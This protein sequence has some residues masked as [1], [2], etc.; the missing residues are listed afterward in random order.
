MK[1]IVKEKIELLPTWEEIISIVPK[2]IYDLIEQSK[3]TPQSLFWH[4]E[5]EVYNHIRIVYNRALKFGDLNLLIAALMHDLGKMSTTAPNNKGGYSAIG[6]EIVS[7]K[8]VKKYSDWINSLGA[9]SEEVYH[10]VND[11][12]RIKQMDIMK[13]PKQDEMRSRPH[14]DK[15]NHFTGF[16]NMKN[17]DPSEMDV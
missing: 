1:K 2:E 6:H 15:L 9:D 17:L 12:M 7:A 16:D 11:H 5:N 10:I 14:F 13:K 8:L 3:T 4:P